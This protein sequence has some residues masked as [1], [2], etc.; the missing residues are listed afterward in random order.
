MVLFNDAI[1]LAKIF[2]LSTST[3][4]IFWPP[5]LFNS[6]RAANSAATSSGKIISGLLCITRLGRER[7]PCEGC[8]KILR[9]LNSNANLFKFTSV[10]VDCGWTSQPPWLLQHCVKGLHVRSTSP[11]IKR[12]VTAKTLSGWFSKLIGKVMRGGVPQHTPSYF[13]DVSFYILLNS[14]CY[15]IWITFLQARNTISVNMELN[16]HVLFEGWAN[17][18]MTTITERELTSF[19]QIAS[20]IFLGSTSACLWQE[21]QPGFHKQIKES[22]VIASISAMPE[23]KSISFGLT[24]GTRFQILAPTYK[25]GK[26]IMGR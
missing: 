2:P 6:S 12:I 5:V 3:P 13:R 9:S 16:H 22:Y 14:N 7:C 11:T 26:S 19:I 24:I 23:W 10:H 18:P 20:T 4:L 25:I 17:Q 21:S 15:M 8:F 1:K